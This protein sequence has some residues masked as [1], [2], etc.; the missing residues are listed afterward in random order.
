MLVHTYICSSAQQSREMREK[1]DRDL[2]Q[3]ISKLLESALHECIL[4]RY[5]VPAA[6]GMLLYVS[7]PIVYISSADVLGNHTSYHQITPAVGVEKAVCL[8]M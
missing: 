5:S 4:S 2:H 8:A 1:Q 7:E 3:H 6:H